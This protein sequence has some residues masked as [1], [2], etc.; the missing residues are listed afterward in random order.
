MT[1]ASNWKK[2]TD[3]QRGFQQL[4]EVVFDGPIQQGCRSGE[5]ILADETEVE[6]VLL[7]QMCEYELENVQVEIISGDH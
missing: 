7:L 6:Q 3:P 5:E 1:S 2:K 4:T